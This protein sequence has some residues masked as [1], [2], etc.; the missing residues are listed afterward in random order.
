MFS[1]IQWN[2]FFF[3]L[4]WKKMSPSPFYLSHLPHYFYTSTCTHFPIL[5]RF[6]PLNG[7]GYDELKILIILDKDFFCVLALKGKLTMH[8]CPI[9]NCAIDWKQQKLITNSFAP[10]IQ[11]LGLSVVPADFRFYLYMKK[12]SVKLGLGMNGKK[13]GNSDNLELDLNSQESNTALLIL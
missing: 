1:F 10:N 5:G 8:N 6:I 2:I 9:L 12:F 13:K 11:T 4:P 7:F 3:S